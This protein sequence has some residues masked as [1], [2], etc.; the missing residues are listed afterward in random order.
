[1]SACLL[2]LPCRYDSREKGAPEII[3]LAQRATVIPICPEQLGGLPTP[4][5]PAE[6]Q[7]GDGMAVLEGKAAVVDATGRPVTGAFLKGAKMAVEIARLTNPRLCILKGKSPSCGVEG[8]LGVAAAALVL[9]GFA[10]EE[11]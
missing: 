5:P 6:L 1:M 8:R 4:R 11:A 7:G 9:A 3:T 10:V 2:G